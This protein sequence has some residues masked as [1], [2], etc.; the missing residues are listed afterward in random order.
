MKSLE[1]CYAIALEYYKSNKKYQCSGLCLLLTK[2][3][4]DDILSLEESLRLKHNIWKNKPSPTLH[5]E[6]YYND[7][8]IYWWPKGEIEQRIKFLQKLMLEAYKPWYLKLWDR[9]K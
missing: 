2:L 6:L 3:Y 1:K 8:N 5:S 7:S 9:L 4:Q